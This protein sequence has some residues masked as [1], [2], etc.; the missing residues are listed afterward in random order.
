MEKNRGREKDGN[1]E[2]SLGIACNF[3]KFL[4]LKKINK[5]EKEEEG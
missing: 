1:H 2:W 4:N 5:K 3:M